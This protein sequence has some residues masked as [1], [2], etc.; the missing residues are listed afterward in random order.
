M[1]QEIFV[2]QNPGLSFGGPATKYWLDAYRSDKPG[3]R[4]SQ[5]L[6]PLKRTTTGA[7]RPLF[8]PMTESHYHCTSCVRR[9]GGT[10]S[11][12]AKQYWAESFIR[13]ASQHTCWREGIQTAY[14]TLLFL[15]SS[16]FLGN[17]SIAHRKRAFPF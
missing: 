3:S 4:W 1:T 17:L 7:H 16:S 14:K 15:P 2:A 6:P 11:W 12:V 10:A 9:V 5:Y 13:H 8:T